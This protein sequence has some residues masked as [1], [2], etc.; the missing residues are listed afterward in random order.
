MNHLSTNWN[1]FSL[2]QKKNRINKWTKKIILTKFPLIKQSNRTR[3]RLQSRRSGPNYWAAR[4][5]NFCAAGVHAINVVTFLCTKQCSWIE[6]A[7]E[8]KQWRFR[9]EPR[10]TKHVMFLTEIEQRSAQPTCTYSIKVSFVDLYLD[11]SSNLINHHLVHASKM[12]IVISKWE[13]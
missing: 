13:N 12:K 3:P 9:G 2:F 11:L 7:S 8:L 6:T 10:D 5:D 1:R 4:A